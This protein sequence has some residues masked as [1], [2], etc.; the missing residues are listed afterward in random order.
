MSPISFLHDL[1]IPVHQCN[2][3]PF[4]FTVLLVNDTTLSFP[5]SLK[6]KTSKIKFLKLHI[7][8]MVS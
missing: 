4:P 7:S 1:V 5:F 3:T 2:K 8:F 6:L